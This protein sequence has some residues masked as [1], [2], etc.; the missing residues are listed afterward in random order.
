MILMPGRLKCDRHPLSFP[1]TDT[2][3][4]RGPDANSDP[5]ID[6]KRETTMRTSIILLSLTA[7][8]A[9]AGCETIQGAGRDLSTVG[10][11]VTTESQE[12]QDQM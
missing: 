1:G 7:L 4:V 5:F 10:E 12:V 11:A 8:L 9:I 3:A 2:A 6:Q